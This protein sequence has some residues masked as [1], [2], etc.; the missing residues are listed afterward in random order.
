MTPQ[1]LK[2]TLRAAVAPFD[3]EGVRRFGKRWASLVDA[4][5]DETVAAMGD[6]AISRCTPE[7]V[8]HYGVKGATGEIFVQGATTVE[9]IPFYYLLVSADEVMQSHHHDTFVRTP[10]YPVEY[11]ERDYER[12]ADQK[13]KVR[14]AVQGFAPQLIFTPAVDAT[15]GPPIVT[16]E[17]EELGCRLLVLSGN[18]R[19]MIVKGAMER[20]GYGK[21]FEA[22]L[23][24]H[25]ESFG[26]SPAQWPTDKAWF[27]D[28]AMIVRAIAEGQHR[29]PA[30][31]S[32]L[33]N[34][35]LA[36]GRAAA[37]DAVSVGRVLPDE[38]LEE[39]GA[40]MIVEDKTFAEVLSRPH[41]QQQVATILM[42][43]GIIP[44]GDRS[45]W[46]E[47]DR[48][49]RPIPRLTRHARETLQ[50][51]LQ[52]NLVGDSALLE[53][54][55]ASV[56]AWAS[57]VAPF[58]VLIDKKL[59][60]AGDDGDPR[61]SLTPSLRKAFAITALSDVGT[62]VD[63]IRAL[64]ETRGLFEGQAGDG[65]D[66]DP[67][68]AIR[69]DDHAA[70]VLAWLISA[71]QKPRVSADKVRAY[72]ESAF[73]GLHDAAVGQ[74]G[75]FAADPLTPSEAQSS[76]LGID[77][78]AV[79]RQ[80]G[81][82]EFLS[83]L[84][85]RGRQSNPSGP[86]TEI[87]RFPVALLRS[88]GLGQFGSYIHEFVALP[89]ARVTSSLQEVVDRGTF[90][91]RG[92][93]SIAIEYRGW[94]YKFPSLR[95]S[96]G[97]IQRPEAA[98]FSD[99]EGIVREAN[100]ARVLHP[101]TVDGWHPF[102]QACLVIDTEAR[103]VALRMEPLTGVAHYGQPLPESVVNEY[104]AAAIYEAF[105]EALRRT[106]KA[107]SD[108]I[109]F[110]F[111]E[112]NVLRFMDYNFW[113]GDKHGSRMFERVYALLGHETRI[114]P[115]RDLSRQLKNAALENEFA[116]FYSHSL[117]EADYA[118]SLFAERPRSF[119]GYDGEA[120]RDVARLVKKARA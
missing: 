70:A 35:S 89:S 57:R 28:R 73:R 29:S 72:S 60:N 63:E 46:F 100:L 86:D 20:E 44:A 41:F 25:A 12:M 85:L 109:Q 117:D 81:A 47:T 40:Q 31:L 39:I 66:G 22:E 84:G 45:R 116:E 108:A 42:R 3:A 102:L 93:F 79:A 96:H 69:A 92:H 105:S 99:P 5:I 32:R 10:G 4:M 18:G 1:Q 21:Q 19:T 59:Q 27:P 88:E 37:E 112:H 90:R 71:V 30:A 75:L 13:E 98:L 97:M 11:Q 49:G 111:D 15:T 67:V 48:E 83:R 103:L 36:Y 34:E 17:C 38:I 101:I 33:F 23:R 78:D 54:Q 104:G 16:R 55:P 106:G 2:T 62:N 43:E 24:R 95:N 113:H 51:G 110:G 7:P 61:W 114:R 8:E 91:G 76:I 68:A 94:I 26:I 65:A 115:Y 64:F 77:A 50:A 14:L 53:R 82:A 120:V 87:M 74:E 9:P 118:L 80:G 52:G 58:L 119:Y 107:P 56:Q 6:C